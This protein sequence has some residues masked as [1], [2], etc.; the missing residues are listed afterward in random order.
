R[1][2]VVP[3]LPA[4]LA[5]LVFLDYQ[6]IL[7]LVERHKSYVPVARCVAAQSE[8]R[9]LGIGT[10]Q[11]NAIG[12]FGFYLDDRRMAVLEDGPRVAEYLSSDVPRAVI[13]YRR[14][15]SRLAPALTLVPHDVLECDDPGAR[16]HDFVLLR[17][18]SGV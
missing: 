14:D 8:G 15:V 5:L 6:L 17:N 2:L 1:A 11:F 16:S 4:A 12:A 7:P 18:R 13:V 9:E 10:V 3:L